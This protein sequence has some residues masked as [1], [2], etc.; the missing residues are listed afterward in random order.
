MGAPANIEG[1][2]K[3][4][5]RRRQSIGEME[6]SRDGTPFLRHGK[7]GDSQI[8]HLTMHGDADK[9]TKGG[10]STAFKNL[11]YLNL[12]GISMPL[13]RPER[14]V[15]FGE[16]RGH[17]GKKGEKPKLK[18]SFVDDNE[19]GEMITDRPTKKGAATTSSAAK[20]KIPKPKRSV[21]A[22]AATDAR[23]IKQASPASSGASGSKS[24]PSKIPKP[25]I[26]AAAAAA[27][28]AAAS[29]VKHA[30]PS[31]SVKKASA[32]A[33]ARAKAAKTKTKVAA[34]GEW[35][36]NESVRRSQQVPLT[37]KLDAML[38]D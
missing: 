14:V 35:A 36:A 29:K 24:S 20:S 26:S 31:V 3:G 15:K 22:A 33:V 4:V 23:K 7:K 16:M 2:A 18:V 9:V 13:R 32:Q 6:I 1:G 21:A 34:R 19:V 28:A 17:T 25:K 12:A 30:R 37:K 5:K 38:A 10:N 8:P 11:P 27:A